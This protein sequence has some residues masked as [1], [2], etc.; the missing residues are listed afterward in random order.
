MAEGL[1]IEEWNRQ[2]QREYQLKKESLDSYEK[3]TPCQGRK[4]P[5]TD[6]TT[7]KEPL[8]LDNQLSVKVKE[9]PSQFQL[10]DYPCTDFDSESEPDEESLDS[11]LPPNVI[12]CEGIAMNK[13]P[14][15]LFENE[16]PF[17]DTIPESEYSCDDTIPETE[18]EDLLDV[19]IPETEDEGSLNEILPEN[20]R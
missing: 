9:G 7:S 13:D 20:G 11:D 12:T 17:N 18:P 8:N 2:Q 19:T 4:N 16:D 14:N 6:G 5:S 10:V 1:K 15:D 3:P